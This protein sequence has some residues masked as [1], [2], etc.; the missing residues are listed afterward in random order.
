MCVDPD[1][2]QWQG[3]DLYAS[4][5]LSTD[6]SL[7]RMPG[8]REQHDTLVPT[9]CVEILNN[10]NQGTD[11]ILHTNLCQQPGIGLHPDYGTVRPTLRLSCNKCPHYFKKF[12]I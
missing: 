12:G 6:L 10:G 8:T 11:L 3:I 1:V 7:L 4:L 9:L 2:I 5:L